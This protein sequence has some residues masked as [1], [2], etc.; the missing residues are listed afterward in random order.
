M[1]GCGFLECAIREIGLIG[2]GITAALS[3]SD[4]GASPEALSGVVGAIVP[5]C[6]GGGVM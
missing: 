6:V 1:N 3:D 2:P 5:P 4:S